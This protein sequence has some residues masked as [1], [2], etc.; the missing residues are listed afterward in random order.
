MKQEKSL[1]EEIV[2]LAE[3]LKQ[4]KTDLS[5]KDTM[6][7]EYKDRMDMIQGEVMTAK[8]LKNE[9]ERLKDLGKKQRLDLEIKENQVRSL[10]SRIETH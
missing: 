1:K 8:D 9:V 2:S 5:R 7:R 3:K 4:C 10:K 6:V